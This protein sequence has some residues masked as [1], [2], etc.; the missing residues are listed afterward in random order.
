MLVVGL[1]WW[2]G[3]LSQG[4]RRHLPAAH[5]MARAPKPA[6]SLDTD[7]F[8]THHVPGNHGAIHSLRKPTGCCCI[9]ARRGSDM[10][11]VCEKF[12]NDTATAATHSTLNQGC[13]QLQGYAFR[14]KDIVRHG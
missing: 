10:S 6:R 9:L 13:E 4:V 11:G 2:D 1:L 5:D 7:V 12:E 8:V 3:V 14:H